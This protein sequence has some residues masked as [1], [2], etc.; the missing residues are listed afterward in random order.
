MKDSNRLIGGIIIGVTSVAFLAYL[1]RKK[2]ANTVPAAPLVEKTSNLDGGRVGNPT[3][4]AGISIS[5]VQPTAGRAVPVYGIGHG[6]RGGHGGGSN[7]HGNG[8]VVGGVG[9]TVGGVVP[10]AVG[11]VY[12]VG[13]YVSP[14]FV[15]G[16]YWNGAYWVG[17]DGLCYQQNS[18]GEYISINCLNTDY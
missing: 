7:G 4:G 14:V 5:R 18:K 2:K 10:V 6:G 3:I 17:Q 11:G 8:R 16:Y 9:R 15:D 1:L 12:P 13:S